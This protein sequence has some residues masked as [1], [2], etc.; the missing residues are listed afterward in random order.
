M[1]GIWS[2]ATSP[3][4]CS[5][6]ADKRSASVLRYLGCFPL[7][8]NRF[9]PGPGNDVL[10]LTLE[11]PIY[12]RWSF[13]PPKAVGG[14]CYTPTLPQN[15][16][17]PFASLLLFGSVFLAAFEILLELHALQNRAYDVEGYRFVGVV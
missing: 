3:A 16:A 1:V 5:G 9:L 4:R 6:A 11:G 10:L 13:R 14:C 2:I 17:V 8:S 12:S 15:T 7:V